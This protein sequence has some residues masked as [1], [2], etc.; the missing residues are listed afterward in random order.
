MTHP[1]LITAAALALAL[2]WLLRDLGPL[3]DLLNDDEERI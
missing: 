3:I 2:D 1:L